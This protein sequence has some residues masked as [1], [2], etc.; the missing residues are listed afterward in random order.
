VDFSRG[1]I[2]KHL[3]ATRLFLK[4]STLLR[5]ARRLEKDHSENGVDL[6]LVCGSMASPVNAKTGHEASD[7]R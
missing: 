1:R 3:L 7:E 5:L 4:D 6:F 2:C